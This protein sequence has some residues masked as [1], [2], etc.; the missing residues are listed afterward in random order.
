MMTPPDTVTRLSTEMQEDIF[1]ALLKSISTNPQGMLL[2]LMGATVVTILQLVYRKE[3][4]AGHKGINLIWEPTEWILY[5][6]SWICPFVLMGAA[7]RVMD[8]PAYVWYFLGFMLIYGLMG[9]KGVEAILAWRGIPPVKQV[10]VEQVAHPQ[11]PIEPAQP[12][13]QQSQ[14]SQP[15]QPPQQ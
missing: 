3:V 4:V 13:Q 15:S 12:S 11:P 8:P 2:F 9:N 7:C 14:P 1:D 5:W 6:F 10:D